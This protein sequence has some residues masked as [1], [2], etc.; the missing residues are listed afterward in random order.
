ML[1]FLRAICE[2]LIWVCAHL[3]GSWWNSVHA[4]IC[5]CICDCMILLTILSCQKAPCRRQG[6][7]V[8][9]TG[10]QCI[11][12][13]LCGWMRGW[14]SSKQPIGQFNYPTHPSLNALKVV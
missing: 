12:D 7:L 4:N 9:F 10:G 5:D 8:V 2:F 6:P 3:F 1:I 11:S 13:V 14:Y